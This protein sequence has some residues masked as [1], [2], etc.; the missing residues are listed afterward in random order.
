MNPTDQQKEE[1]KLQKHP[2]I[3]I[4]TLLR[5]PSESPG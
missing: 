1:Q 5:A 4:P 2:K 3:V